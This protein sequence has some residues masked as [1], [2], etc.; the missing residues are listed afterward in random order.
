MKLWCLSWTVTGGMRKSRYFFDEGL[1]RS[2]QESLDSKLAG[3]GD[4]SML[5]AVEVEGN[6]VVNSVGQAS[7]GGP[8]C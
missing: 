4:S 7:V 5:D 2:E 3:Y 6:L 8:D 1:A